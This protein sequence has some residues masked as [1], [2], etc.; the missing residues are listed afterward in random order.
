MT[1]IALMRNF[2]GCAVQNC[3]VGESPLLPG[4][5]IQFDMLGGRRGTTPLSS[6]I[7]LIGAPFPSLSA[8]EQWDTYEMHDSGASRAAV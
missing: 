4:L 6:V 3:R 1:S 2:V 5:S 7:S 8:S